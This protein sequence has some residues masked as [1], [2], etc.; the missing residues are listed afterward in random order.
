MDRRWR[1]GPSALPDTPRPLLTTD[2]SGTS[3]ETTS[4][5]HTG[6]SLRGTR[7]GTSLLTN[8]KVSL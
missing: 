1:R 4:R 5:D 3:H 6:T 7:D 2:V 8:S